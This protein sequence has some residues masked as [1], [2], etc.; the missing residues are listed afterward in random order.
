[1]TFLLPVSSL[2][3][4]LDCIAALY[5][6]PSIMLGFYS[7]P[8]VLKK[9]YIDTLFPLNDFYYVHWQACIDCAQLLA[10]RPWQ[11]WLSTQLLWY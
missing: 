11:E 5:L 1:M 10:K 8:G 9:G 7:L 4:L 3:T 6:I 2:G